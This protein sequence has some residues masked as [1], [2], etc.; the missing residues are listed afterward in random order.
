MSKAGTQVTSI[1]I[2]PE[3]LATVRA[4][5][6]GGESYDELLPKMAEQ[7]KPHQGRE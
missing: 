7:Y 5:K 3:T 6:T 1:V 4:C 2:S